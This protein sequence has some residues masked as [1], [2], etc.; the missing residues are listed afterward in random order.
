MNMKLYPNSITKYPNS[1]TK[2]D[3]DNLRKKVTYSITKESNLSIFICGF[4]LGAI[5]TLIIAT[6]LYNIV[7]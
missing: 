5:L 2:K 7:S 6:V 1:I 4:A 3:A